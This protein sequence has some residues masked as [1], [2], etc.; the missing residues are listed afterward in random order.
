MVNSTHSNGRGLEWSGIPDPSASLFRMS[1]SGDDYAK[2]RAWVGQHCRKSDIFAAARSLM[3]AAGYDGVQMQAIAAQCNISAQTIY[4]L[5]GS[6]AQVMEQAAADWVESIRAAAVS[7]EREAG[8]SSVFLMIEMF[9]DSALVHADWVRIASKHSA[10]RGDPLTGAFYRAATTALTSEV[11]GLQERGALRCD[12][13]VESL[14]RQLTATAHITISNWCAESIDVQSYRRDLIS[15][16]GAMLRAWLQGPE[17]SKL[18][19]YIAARRTAYPA[20]LLRQ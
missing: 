6:K 5:V 11:R 17:L 15:G 18:E 1:A 19:C 20:R 9:W 10:A 7:R 2:G 3:K 13:D 8:V 16:P 12:A 14:A 4:N